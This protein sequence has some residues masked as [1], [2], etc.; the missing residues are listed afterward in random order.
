M[1]PIICEEEEEEKSI[2]HDLLSLFFDYSPPIL[3]VL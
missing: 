3:V 1:E 2:C